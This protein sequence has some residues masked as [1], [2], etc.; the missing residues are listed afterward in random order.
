MDCLTFIIPT[1]HPVQ[2][3]ESTGDA[4]DTEKLDFK[5]KRGIIEALKLTAVLFIGNREK[6]IKIICQADAAVV[7]CDG[8][9]LWHHYS[10]N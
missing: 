8:N 3:A 2:F 5:A 6:K 1:S 4:L 10:K 7:N 9:F